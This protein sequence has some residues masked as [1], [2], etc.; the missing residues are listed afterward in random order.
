MSMLRLALF[1]MLT[2][3]AVAQCPP[4]HFVGSYG[5][6]CVVGT[7][8]PAPQ[9]GAFAYP[10]FGNCYLAFLAFVGGNSEG[11]DYVAVGFAPASPGL[12]LPIG[13]GCQLLV[14]PDVLLIGHSHWIPPGFPLAV[15]LY[16]QGIVVEPATGVL[17]L[18]DGGIVTVN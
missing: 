1:L 7:A 13:A 3:A 6:G 16:A 2:P 8:G 15:T 11:V 10:I 4:V 9:I 14:Q 18:T 17:K 5:Q 12:S